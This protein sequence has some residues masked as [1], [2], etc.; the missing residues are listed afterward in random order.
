MAYRSE[1]NTA[2]C[3]ADYE[4]NFG[5]S[6]VSLHQYAQSMQSQEESVSAGGDSSLGS[7]WCA[8]WLIVAKWRFTG[9]PSDILER[10]SS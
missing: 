9:N 7:Y 10:T 4:G 3:C 2:I 8:N 1:W 5:E 6:E